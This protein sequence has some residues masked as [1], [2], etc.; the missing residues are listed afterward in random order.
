MGFRAAVTFCGTLD[1]GDL[2]D[3]VDKDFSC[4]SGTVVGEQL[5]E[6]MTQR[7]EDF[8]GTERWMWLRGRPPGWARKTGSN[9][10]EWNGKVIR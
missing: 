5:H 1:A 10:G 3:S 7:K 8:K 2:S 9:A 6:F 4:P